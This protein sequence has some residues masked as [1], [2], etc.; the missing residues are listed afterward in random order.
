MA[1]LITK[2]AR[3]SSRFHTLAVTRVERLTA[4]FAAEF[5]FQ[6]GQHRTVRAR[7]GGQYVR[8]SYSICLS[9]PKALE[10]KELR[11]AAARVGGGLLSNWI[12]DRLKAG[13]RM[14]VM[15]PLGEFTCAMQPDASRHHVA[16][17]AGSGITSVMSLFP[18]ALAEEPASR[19]TIIF[20]NR[21]TSSIMLRQ[22]LEDLSTQ[23]P[24]RFQLINALSREGTADELFSGRLDRERIHL[25]LGTLAPAQ[26]VD[27]WYL[28]GPSG[29]VETARRLVADLG[30]DLGHVHEEVFDVDE[31]PDDQGW[32]GPSLTTAGDPCVSA[33][34]AG[35]ARR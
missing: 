19:A 15:T 8:R 25:I 9:R 27:Q 26:T 31:A 5:A 28:R 13:D 22:E 10:P 35:C 18:T 7:V 4:E 11:I 24:D 12:N 17:V 32:A 2:R 20:G 30:V 1:S 14:E 16:I 21:A 23:Y 34:S 33:A 29:L 3:R 6:L